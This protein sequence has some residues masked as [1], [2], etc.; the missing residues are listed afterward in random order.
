MRS[1]AAVGLSF[2]VTV[3]VVASSPAAAH[4]ASWSPSFAVAGAGSLDAAT[5]LLAIAPTGAAAFGLGSFDPDVAGSQRAQLVLRRT[6]G[7]LARARTLPGAAQ[8]LALAY[9]GSRLTILEGTTS[10]EQDCCSAVATATVSAGGTIG[11][12]HTLVSGLAGETTGSLLP[13]TNG[14]MIAVVATDRGVWTAQSSKTGSFP[15]ARQIASRHQQPT[16][17]SATSLG[18]LQA[19]VAWTSVTGTLTTAAPRTIDVATGTPTSTPGRGRPTI[20][21]ASGHRVDEVAIAG[22]GSR[23]T[24]AFTESW[25]DSHGGYHSQV[26]VADLGA[27]TPRPHALSSSSRIASGLQLVA[28]AAGDESI[29]WSACAVGG[30][31]TV[32]AAGR[33][34]GAGFGSIKTLGPDDG[35]APPSLAI[36]PSGQVVAGWIHGGAPV[37]SVGFGAPDDAVADHRRGLGR[38]RLWVARGAGHLVAG[39]GHRQRPWRGLP[40]Q[41]NSFPAPSDAAAS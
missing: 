27:K 38:R 4:A 16:A 31:C 22:H 15:A 11:A 30:A 1:A 17:V 37:A 41:L 2:T 21:V 6:S 23:R 3:A 9:S 25:Y 13:L 10:G 29:A 12:R 18:G 40:R 39:Y 28:D 8:V 34:A 19:A 20:T 26:E 32:Q 5:P 33:P 14:R 7:S 35:T 36:S 24:L